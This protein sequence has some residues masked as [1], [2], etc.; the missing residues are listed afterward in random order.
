[1][2]RS[3]VPL[4]PTFYYNPIAVTYCVIGVSAISL[5]GC[6]LIVFLKNPCLLRASNLILLSMT[7]CD[8]MVNVLASPVGAYANAKRWW[9]LSPS[10]CHY[11]GFMTTWLSLTSILHISALAAERWMTIKL[12]Q[13][14]SRSPRRILVIVSGLWW[15][16]L[17]WSLFPLFGWSSY[18][19]EPGFAGCSIEW[20][21]STLMPK[22]YIAGTFTF[23][24]FVPV[25]I[26]ASCFIRTYLEV[27]RL[28][29]KAAL[30]WGTESLP[31]KRSLKAKIKAARMSVI[32][33]V[34]FFMAW[35]PYAIM[36]LKTVFTPNHGPPLLSVAAAMFAK[37]ASCYNPIIYF[38]M[39]HKFR[40][41]T[42]S[43]V[44]MRRKSS[45]EFQLT[46]E[47]N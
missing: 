38:F 29:K 47:K 12:K 7:L 14:R 27:S 18:S 16:A 33:T 42:I 6:A 11:Y 5:N 25:V 32:M 45:H 28:I 34:A 30:R 46:S 4:L 24:F 39:Y 40:S 19:P 8:L 26:I 15:F 35:T 10:V 13:P 9:T 36:S 41:A 2:N 1:M 22:F 23:F 37:M 43:L 20:Y 31:T 3:R 44:Q 17:T 21:S